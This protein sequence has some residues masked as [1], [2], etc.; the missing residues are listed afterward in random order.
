MFLQPVGPSELE[1]LLSGHNVAFIFKF[2]G[3]ICADDPRAFLHSLA[4]RVLVWPAGSLSQGLWLI[5][6][7]HSSL[8]WKLNGDF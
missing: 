6:L 5:P 3:F 7:Y 2:K 4:S 1:F 8:A